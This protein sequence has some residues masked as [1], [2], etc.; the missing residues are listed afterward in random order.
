MTTPLASGFSSPDN[1]ATDGLSRRQFLAAAASVAAATSLASGVLGAATAPQAG[2]MK[3]GLFS[4]T[5]LGL[6]YR[7]REL[8]LEEVVRRAKRGGYE[9]M[10]IDGKRPHANPL[11]WPKRRCRELRKF[12]DGEGIDI[13]SVAADNDFSS[14]IPE[15]RE[16]EVA[17]VREL[18]RMAADFGA[19]TLRVFLAWP[20]VTRHPRL[21]RYDI[22]RT[23]WEEAH[24]KFTAE[25]IWEWCREGMIE[26]AKYAADFGV[27]LALQNHK[28]VIND[29]RDVLRMV[30]EV[31]SP[32]LKVCLDAPI[33]SDKR[34]EAVRQAAL[35]VGPLQVLS[36][37]GGEY[38]RGADG[39]VRPFDPVAGKPVADES[40]LAFARAMR[41]IGYSGYLGYELC[42]P[43]HKV[44]GEVVGVEYAE[45]NAE[46]ACEYMREVMKAS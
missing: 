35:D 14:P 30:R 34:S 9:G 10:E 18:L 16:C 36:H 29:H 39:R 20:G 46:L 23:L 8:P 1:S 7:G 19:R 43:L 41:E 31:G 13:Y 2:G 44:N 33:M 21:G 4:I 26:A 11:D 37:F 25:E 28:P 5:F 40:S 17:Y 3:L 6:W 24:K 45:K 12:A 22:A 32:N 42:H 15:H 27:T 38:E